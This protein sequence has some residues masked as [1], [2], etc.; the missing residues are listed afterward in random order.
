MRRL[1]DG[2]SV[3]LTEDRQAGRGQ[4]QSW[5]SRKLARQVRVPRTETKGAFKSRGLTGP[6]CSQN[7]GVL[8]H[9]AGSTNSPCLLDAITVNSDGNLSRGVSSILWAESQKHEVQNQCVI[10]KI[11]Y[12]GKVT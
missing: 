9:I 12:E 6:K 3:G 1:V 2:L 4:T 11:P 10:F 5:G 7:P 8:P